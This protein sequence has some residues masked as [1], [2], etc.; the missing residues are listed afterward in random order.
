MPA[1]PD[2]HARRRLDKKICRRDGGRRARAC[3]HRRSGRGQRLARPGARPAAGRAGRAGFGHQP[4]REGRAAPAEDQLPPTHA[5]AP[6]PRRTGRGAPQGQHDRADHAG[7]RVELRDLACR[8]RRGCARPGPC[9]RP[10]LGTLA[11]RRRR[12][13]RAGGRRPAGRRD[14]GPGS[15]SRPSRSTA[16]SGSPPRPTGPPSPRSWRTRSRRWWPS[17][18]TRPHR[19]AAR[20]GW[21]SRCTRTSPERTARWAAS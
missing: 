19:A 15:G 1:T 13:D 21:S 20:T 9:P 17:T 18:T 2:S 11:D 14:R 7:H 5:G 8:A 10:A 16:R 6:R 3:C 12:P 4:R